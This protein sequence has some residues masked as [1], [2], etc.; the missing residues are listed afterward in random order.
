MDEDETSANQ[1]SYAEYS[2]L[3][4]V[5]ALLSCANS[6]A[7]E[8][9]G[10]FDWMDRGW[11]LRWPVEIINGFGLSPSAAKT[12]NGD[13]EIIKVHFEPV[14]GD[15]HSYWSELFGPNAP[16]LTVC[17][18]VSDENP[19]YISPTDEH[20]L[21]WAWDV[22]EPERIAACE[23]AIAAQE[24]LAIGSNWLELATKA[25]TDGPRSVL[26]LGVKD[27]LERAN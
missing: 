13:Q 24:N 17:F 8:I 1:L 12:I 5:M 2:L 22:S 6:R 21:H 15:G 7:M 3:L 10:G 27:Y 16:A 14:G 19:P 26:F 9:G 23:T 18:E 20:W 25:G 4:P 11:Q